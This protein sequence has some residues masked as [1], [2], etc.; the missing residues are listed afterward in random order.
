MMCVGV[1]AAEN[2]RN[3]ILNRT[4]N[5]F[6]RFTPPLVRLPLERDKGGESHLP[7]LSSVC[8]RD[9][10]IHS[11]LIFMSATSAR[12]AHSIHGKEKITMFRRH[13][14]IPMAVLFFILA[15]AFSLTIW[16]ETSLAAKIAFFV[17]GIGCGMGICRSVHADLNRDKAYHVV[18]RGNSGWVAAGYC[19]KPETRDS[20][21][22]T[23][24]K[25]D[26]S[27]ILDPG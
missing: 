27:W 20:R 9:K 8:R 23:R 10:Y 15:I 3:V 2:T 24:E 5:T 16:S 11:C 25:K 1:E 14:S 26:R 17:T 4:K 22:E 13:R 12:S 18:K 19:L 7:S 21:L 6:R